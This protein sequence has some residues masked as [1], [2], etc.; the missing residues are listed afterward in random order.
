MYLFYSVFE[1]QF[2]FD[3]SISDTVSVLLVIIERG[4]FI[5]VIF[6]ILTLE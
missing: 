6:S 4:M 3:R 5:K 1:F 2:L